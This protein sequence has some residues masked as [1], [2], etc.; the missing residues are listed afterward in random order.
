MPFGLSCIQESFCT[1]KD[2]APPSRPRQQL[3]TPLPARR[4][5]G[6]CA[7]AG[8]QPEGLWG[9]VPVP[10]RTQGLPSRSPLPEPE[11]E[12]F[13]PLYAKTELQNQNISFGC[14]RCVLVTLKERAKSVFQRIA[15]ACGV[16]LLR[17]LRPSWGGMRSG[18]SSRAGR[19]GPGG[20]GLHLEA[21]RGWQTSTSL[22]LDLFFYVMG[23]VP[24]N[25]PGRPGAGRGH[26]AL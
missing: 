4:T 2:V 15:E 22:S 20:A 12:E 24:L 21:G 11:K 14:R 5:P 1:H 3:S 25:S 16:G 23:M 19:P 7:P 26:G 6:S 18:P 17:R 10:A 9:S 8:S 13:V